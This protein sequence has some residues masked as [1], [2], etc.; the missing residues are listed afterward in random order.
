MDK[1]V[2][3]DF[4]KDKRISF[5]FPSKKCK[6]RQRKLGEQRSVHTNELRRVVYSSDTQLRENHFRKDREG[7]GVVKWWEK[8]VNK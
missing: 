2:F 5:P 6:V 3:F 7:K 4:P 8:Q 1:S